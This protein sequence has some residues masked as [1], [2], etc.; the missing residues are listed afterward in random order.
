MQQSGKPVAKLAVPCAFARPGWKSASGE[1]T[2]ALRNKQTQ[3]AMKLGNCNLDDKVQCGDF[4]RW[5]G[6]SP[7]RRMTSQFG[8][9]GKGTIHKARAFRNYAWNKHTA[10]E[11][12]DKGE[13][14]TAQGYEAICQRIAK[15]WEI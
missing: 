6:N 9:T 14:E 11:L 2:T 13:I 8:L 10:N 15:G 3:S 12:R 1:S 5:H 4:I 7:S